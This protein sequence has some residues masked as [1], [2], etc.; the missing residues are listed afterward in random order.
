MALYLEG[1]E[2]TQIRDGLWQGSRPPSGQVVRD[3]GFSLL[4]LCAKEYQL[5]AHK[6]VGVEVVSVSTTDSWWWPPAPEAIAG[7]KSAAQKV[8][9]TLRRGDKALVTCFAG[10]NRSSVVSC[11]SL[12]EAFGMS[13]R[14]AID[15]V[16]E[17][18]PGTLTNP[19]FL[20]WLKGV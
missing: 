7:W 9:E 1:I 17:R 13:A 3:A 4:V 6:F 16:Q 15:L 19:I 8:V 18:R 10:I 12:M 11:L 2:A 5:P 20:E 14:E